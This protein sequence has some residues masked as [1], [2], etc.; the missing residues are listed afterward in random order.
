MKASEIFELVVRLAGFFTVLFAA[1]MLLTMVPGPL[2]LSF[3]GL[4]NVVAY[5]ALGVG[6]IKGGA[7]V[8]DFAYPEPGRRRTGASD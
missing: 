1:Y 7:A 5:A 4:V 6:L 2:G 3:G 8:R